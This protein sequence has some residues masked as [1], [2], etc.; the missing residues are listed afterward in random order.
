MT[1]RAVLVAD[2][3]TW[4][5]SRRVH[6]LSRYAPPD[7]ETR[8]RYH[9]QAPKEEICTPA[10]VEWADVL[11]N[12]DYMR[13][14]YDTMILKNGFDTKLVISH[15][16]DS[17]SRLENWKD[18]YEPVTKVDGFLVCNNLEVFDHHGRLPRTC[19]IS[20][21]V[22]AEVWK[23]LIPIAD[24]PKR[25]I[26]C[27]GSNVKKGKGY[28]DIL[29]TM[30]PILKDKGFE[31]DF[32]AYHGGSLAEWAYPTEKQLEWY[33]GASIVVCAS[34]HEGTPNFVSEGA[35][36]GCVPVSTFVGNIREWGQHRQNCVICERTVEAMVDG[37]EYAWEHRER[38]SAAAVETMRGWTYG[39]PGNR[40]RYFW[41]LFRRLIE[42][43]PNSIEP[44]SYFEKRPEEI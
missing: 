32:R 19:N 23:C 16:R 8:I 29:R 38:L 4:A 7:F 3:P 33:N 43:G 9:S 14:G 31:T 34:E 36:C 6:A 2:V 24:R 44:F 21:G 20:N 27:G 13:R 35:I 25:V 28:F 5:Y 12:I 42:D 11:F 26:W 39:E 1:Y 41:Q 30:E 17:Q 37:I 18:S 15:N 40:A 10:D 22:D